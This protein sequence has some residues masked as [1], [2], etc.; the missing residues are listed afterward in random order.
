MCPGLYAEKDESPAI[1]NFALPA[2]QQPYGLFA[3]GGNIIDKGETQLFFFADDFEGKKREI[4][5]LIP[6][7]LVGITEKLSL[8]ANLP[9]APS[10]RESSYRSSGLQDFFIQGEYAIYGKK[11]AMYV[12]QATIV[13]N[14]SAP[15]GSVSKNPSTGYGSP[16]VFVGATF[17]RM[18]VKWFALT[19][20]GAIIST[21]HRQTKLGSQYLYQCGFGRNIDSPKGWIYAWMLEIDGQ[22]FERDSYQGG[23]DTNSGGNYVFV[24]PS[25]WISSQRFLCQFGISAPVS[26]RLLGD[27]HKFD[28]VLNFN[29]AWSF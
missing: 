2:S 23:I 22:Y 11:T 13:G 28:F 18:M 15:T 3:F 16:S 26:Q 20:Y 7:V 9:Y 4:I 19:S 12:D 14:V 29:L 1:G 21:S 10:L 24:T 5:E 6:S 25:L 8:L 27:Q 17:C